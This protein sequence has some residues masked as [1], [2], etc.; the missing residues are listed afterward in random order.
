VIF[1]DL[2]RPTDAIAAINRAVTLNDNRAVYRSR[3]LLDSDLASKNI[4]LSLLYNQLGLTAWARN[5]AMASVKQDYNN[6]SGHLFLSGALRD[7]DDRSWSFVGESLLARM[8]QPANVNTFNTFNEYTAFFEKPAINGTVSGTIGENNTSSGEI[9]LDGAIPDMNLALAAG[10]VYQETDGW[11]NTNGERVG[12][13]AA[14]GKWDPTMKDGLMAVFSTQQSKQKDGS[15]PRYDWDAPRDPNFWTDSNLTRIELG[16]H[17]HFSP[18]SDLLLHYTH[19][20]FK[21]NNSLTNFMRDLP[22]PPPMTI[23]G[24]SLFSGWNETPYDQL[25]GQ[26]LF[27]AGS[28]QLI[29]GS[30]QYRGDNNMSGASSTDVY[31]IKALGT[32]FDVSI[33][34]DKRQMQNDTGRRSQSYY[35]QDSWKIS[36]TLSVEGALYFDQMDNGDPV[37]NTTWTLNE[38]NPRIGFILTPTDRDTFRLAAFRYLLPYITSRIDPM[39]IG[40]VPVLRN[41]S[42]GA[43]MQEYDLSWEREWKSGFLSFGGFY[44]EKVYTHKIID[45]ASVTVEQNDRGRMRGVELTLNQL[46]WRGMGLA[47]SYRYQDVDDDNLPEA[48]REDHLIVAGL[49]YV[50]ALGLA[51]SI[52]ETYRHERF[53]SVSRNDEDIWLTDA[54]VGYEFPKKKGSI[55]LECRN[56]FNQ[57]FNW[58]TDYFVF[59]G[60]APVRETL[61]TLT[62]NF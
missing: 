28:H 47:A 8:L 59:K 1:R 23:L 22:G 57:H 34:L 37:Y 49:K 48:N 26:F 62:L 13:F 58:V 42:Q 29:L 53:K 38:W 2:N 11:R 60:R 14:Y 9:I 31:K 21:S 4:D 7:S 32:V 10:G 36:R 46:L 43:V 55:N 50:H 44:L 52:A 56:I 5:K 54:K 61:L 25:Q 6:A 17:H 19:M 18:R 27:K 41:N 12:N 35:L 3:F 33:N 51:A 15:Y 39:D 24:N 45:A 40:G 16:Y 20:S 30:V